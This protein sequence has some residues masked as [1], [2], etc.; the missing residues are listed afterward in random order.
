MN[1]TAVNGTASYSSPTTS[2]L[3]S[4]GTPYITGA[5][6]GPGK[7][8]T[9]AG[10]SKRINIGAIVGGVVGGV[11]LLVLILLM[12]WYRKKLCRIARQGRCI[13]PTRIS[14]SVLTS[15]CSSVTTTG[16]E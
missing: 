8:D 15:F 11:L 2:G 14:I 9:P 16:A 4:A 12:V 13:S 6:T 10:D 1:G 7:G 5:P 3:E